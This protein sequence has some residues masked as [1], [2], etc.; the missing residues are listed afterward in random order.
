MK[1]IMTLV[2][3]VGTVV[4]LAILRGYRLDQAAHDAL[5]RELEE[6]GVS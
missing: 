1:G 2:P 6:R 4:I 5:V 3:A